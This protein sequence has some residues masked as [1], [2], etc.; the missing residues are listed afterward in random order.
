MKTRKRISGGKRRTCR[1]RKC[2]SR[3]YK[4]YKRHIKGGGEY[5]NIPSD[6]PGIT[7]K[8]W[9]DKKGKDM[10]DIYITDKIYNSLTKDLQTY[11]IRHEG[12]FSRTSGY[13]VEKVKRHPTAVYNYHTAIPYRN[14]R[15]HIDSVQKLSVAIE[16]CIKELDSK[17]YRR[18]VPNIESIQSTYLNQNILP[19]P[20]EGNTDRYFG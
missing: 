19:A 9:S 15:K 3:K 14:N 17:T 4:T 18:N 20:E 11:F 7:Y 1:A 2:I 10:R 16:K 8:Y 5:I 6:Y 12:I 13:K